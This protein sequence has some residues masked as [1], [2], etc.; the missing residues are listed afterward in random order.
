[1]ATL[2]VSRQNTTFDGPP[3]G[4]EEAIEVGNRT[5]TYRQFPRQN[6]LRWQC[7]ETT[8]FVTGPIGRETLVEIAASVD[9]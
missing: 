6:Q 9:C 8:Q 5:G 2:T 4:N 3:G 1:V 7:E